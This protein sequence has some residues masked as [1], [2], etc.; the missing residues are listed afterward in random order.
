M[1]ALKWIFRIVLTVIFVALT[2]VV[3]IAL[4]A[5]GFISKL[6]CALFLFLIGIDLIFRLFGV[7]LSGFATT[8]K[9]FGISFLM[10]FVFMLLDEG[11]L[12]SAIDKISGWL[13]SLT[14]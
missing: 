8:V 4:K 9:Y 14:N 1:K 3:G 5:G 11:V 13:Q 10:M 7:I 12:E 6:L 2:V